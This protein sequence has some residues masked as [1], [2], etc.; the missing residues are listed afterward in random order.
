MGEIAKLIFFNLLPIVL[1]VGIVGFKI[2]HDLNHLKV[3]VVDGFIRI[4]EE[5]SIMNTNISELQIQI[6]KNSTAD[7]YRDKALD[8]LDKEIIRLNSKLNNK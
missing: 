8:R 2:Y 1:S 4:S 6:V 5:M 7:E 3:T